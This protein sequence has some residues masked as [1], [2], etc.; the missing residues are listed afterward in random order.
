MITSL[1]EKQSKTGKTSQKTWAVCYTLEKKHTNMKASDL[2]IKL[3][4]LP[5]SELELIKVALN[6]QV[7]QNCEFEGKVERAQKR[8]EVIVSGMGLD[9]RANN[10]RPEAPKTLAFLNEAKA[11]FAKGNVRTKEI[12]EL[13]CKHTVKLLTAYQALNRH[14][15]GSV[16]SG[17][18]GKRVSSLVKRT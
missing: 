8:S 10:K 18:W 13:A 4:S 5:N 6:H 3:F 17:I 12:N 11:R 2:L 15:Y 1:P 9:R 7:K 14:D 16:E